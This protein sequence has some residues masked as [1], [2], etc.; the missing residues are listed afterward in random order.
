MLVLEDSEAIR[1]LICSTV[2]AKGYDCHLMSDGG[3]AIACYKSENPMMA[4]IDLHI[5]GE[6][7]LD[8]IKTL[9][10]DNP[11]LVIIAMTAFGSH[12]NAFR[13]L[14]LGANDYLKKPFRASELAAL[15]DR[16]TAIITELDEERL[17]K[18]F[19]RAKSLTIEMGN[20]LSH[21]GLVARYLVDE[22]APFLPQE[23]Q[24]NVRLGLEELLM[25]AVEHGN[26]E[27]SSDEKRRLLKD[28]G[29]MRILFEERAKSA[30]YSARTVRVEASLSL[31]VCEWT[32]TDQGGGFDHEHL[33]DPTSPE[34]VEEL[35]GRGIFLARFQF[36][37][38]DFLGCGNVVRARK[39]LVE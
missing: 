13:A 38:V 28:N 39:R 29:S 6:N 17:L 1:E 5:P 31:D 7:P 4:F 14:R 16:Y 15:V 24:L 9:R 33:P 19:L 12:E 21:P 2:R 26:L 32:I 3:S 37:E 30:V 11:A 34:G 20:D 10:R 27:I 8:V 23:E 22:A 18:S 25:N 35:S 36:T